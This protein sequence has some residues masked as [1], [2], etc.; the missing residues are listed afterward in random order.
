MPEH[1]H[2]DTTLAAVS[3]VSQLGF[4]VQGNMSGLNTNLISVHWCRR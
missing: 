4:S 1:T 3:F 2:T